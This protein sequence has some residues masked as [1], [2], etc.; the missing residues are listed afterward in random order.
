MTFA[1][2]VYGGYFGAGVGIML[3]AVLALSIE[4]D[5]QRLNALKSVLSLLIGAVSVAYF[6][7]AAPV[8]WAAAAVMAVTALAGGH[9]GVGFARRLDE[10][11]LRG[12]VIA[13]GTAVAL[14][15]LL[16]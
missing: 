9:V 1:A 5:L 13:L 15:L 14:L 7:F 6:V 2:A 12:L 10:R 16:G 4:D 8:E 3:L 11:L